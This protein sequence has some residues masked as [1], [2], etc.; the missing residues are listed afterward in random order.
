MSKLSRS[1]LFSVLCVFV[2]NV[3]AN[4]KLNF[5]DLISGPDTGLD[6]GKGSGVVVTIWGQGLG[7]SRKSSTITFTDSK[8]KTSSSAH[9]YYWKNADGQLP[10]GPANLFESHKMQ[11]IAFSI[12]NMA[13]GAGTI[14]VTVNGKETNSLP[15]TI[16]SGDIYH[17]KASGND[18]TGNGSFASPW[19]TIVSAIDTVSN[20]GSTIYV[21]DN[22]ATVNLIDKVGAIFWDKGVASSGVSNQYGI[23]AFPNSHPSV[24]GI[25]GFT[26]YNAQGQ[27]ISKYKAFA[28][29]CDEGPNSQ[30]INCNGNQTM[31]I[32]ASAYGRTVGNT[33]SDRPGGCPDA[34]SSAVNGG[35]RSGQDRISGYQMLGNEVYEYGCLGSNRQQHTTYFTIRSAEENL[36]L[37]AWHVGWNY[38]HDNSARNGIHMFDENLG[39]SICGSPT[40]TVVVNDNVVVNQGGAGIHIGV[41]CPWV[42]DFEVYNNVMINTGLATGWNGVDVETSTADERSAITIRDDGL[43]GTFDI[44]NN[45]MIGWGDDVE[46]L[47][48]PGCL[49]L[50]GSQDNVDIKWNNNV[51]IT[52][53]DKLF[54]RF[55]KSSTGLADNVSGSSNVWYA[56][57]SSKNAVKPTW[58]NSAITSNPLITVTGSKLAVGAG[59]PLIGRLN[60]NLSHDIYGNVR[61]P[62]GEIGAVEFFTSRKPKSPTDIAV[63][64]K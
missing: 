56:G 35:T 38:L 51:C 13:S 17:V 23:V 55:T 36:Q 31:V 53:R 18:S 50:R 46:S 41:R 12:P 6:D 3:Y 7:S 57:S 10:S 14:S 62:G 29:E 52:D 60:N 39:G 34:Q 27:V 32:Q 2:S 26:N 5:S 24:T 58:D 25:A 4:P 61:Q 8:G 19:A 63:K 47:A 49:V 30:P 22:L 1:F 54:I 21:H 45:T 33:V 48:E 11:E 44:Y 42:S 15:F 9:I 59:S 28:S 16:R 64:V 40:G 43:L 20:P 37:P